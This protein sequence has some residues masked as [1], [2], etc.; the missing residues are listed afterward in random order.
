MRIRD[1]YRIDGTLGA[2]ASSIVYAGEDRRTGES[3]A[4]K[5]LERSAV[6]GWF[7]ETHAL[8]R[9]RHPSIVSLYDFGVDGESELPFVVIERIEGITLLDRL[10]TEGPASERC[11]ARWMEQLAGALE[12][13]H[14]AGIVHRD[15]KP[16]NVMFFGPRLESVK[17]LDFGLA[18]DLNRKRP[19]SQE[20][21]GL[22][23]TPGFVSP[24][25]ATHGRVDARSDLYALGCLMYAALS[26]RAPYAGVELEELLEKQTREPPPPLPCRLADG[27]APSPSALALHES[28]LA[29]SPADRPC[30]AS[31][32]RAKFRSLAELG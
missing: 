28:L 15:L 19:R 14:G 3:V 9:L 27:S 32:A 21:E 29:C 10:R 20:N 16:T 18:L 12:Y 24:E 13:V 5:I 1:R 30:S 17:L 25:Q 2:G 26:A 6:V 31:E 4:I 23:G 7:R 8:R 22:L 11:A